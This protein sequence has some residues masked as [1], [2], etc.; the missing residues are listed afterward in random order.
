MLH[1]QDKSNLEDILDDTTTLNIASTTASPLV[2]E[3]DVFWNVND[4]DWMTEQQLRNLDS[5]DDW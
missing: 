2:E 1:T 4:N 5:F 3:S